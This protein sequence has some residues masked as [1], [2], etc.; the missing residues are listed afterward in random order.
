MYEQFFGLRE[1]PFDLTPNPR[2]LVL[3]A[4]HRE[5][6]STLKYGMSARK[7]LTVLVGEA[8]TG[9]TTL[10]RA[11]LESQDQDHALCVH[12]N[13]PMLSRAEFLEFLAHGF[14]LSGAAR[15]SKA[16]F[17]RELE[18][19]LVR[20]SAAAA[21]TLLVIDE[22]QSLSHDL[23]EEVRL[24]AN[25]ETSEDKLLPVVLAGQPELGA[26]LNSPGLRQLKQRVALRCAL[27]PLTGGETATYIANRTCLAGAEQQLFTRE[28][29][30]LIHAEAK[31]IPRTISVICDNALVSGFA[32]GRRPVD[33]PLVADVC[34]DFDLVAQGPLLRHA[35]SYESAQATPVAH[36][37][38]LHPDDEG[39]RNMRTNTGSS[40]PRRRK[41]SFF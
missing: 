31:G 4:Q 15:A 8:G 13:N 10:V 27:R 16:V 17:L 34:R 36:P 40:I 25:I 3:L 38:S 5:A 26:L 37:P 12:V 30:A 23:L 32:V 28:A 24:L 1:R 41:L 19:L 6:L 11:A 20:R 21:P 33:S 29:I 7:G 14:G 39:E 9:K 22:A 18:A 35:A 2:F